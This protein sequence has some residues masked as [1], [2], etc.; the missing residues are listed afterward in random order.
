MT[1]ND[2]AVYRLDFAGNEFLVE[3]NLSEEQARQ[4]VAKFESYK[5]HQYYWCARLPDSP[6]PTTQEP[7]RDQAP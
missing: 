4:L 1:D 2:W 7:R 3:K 5:H 6:I